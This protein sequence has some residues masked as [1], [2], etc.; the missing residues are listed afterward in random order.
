MALSWLLVA[1]H[2]AS[3]LIG[4]V[5]LL[6]PLLRLALAALLFALLATASLVFL[7]EERRLIAAGI[8]RT[9]SKVGGNRS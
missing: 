7:A 9:A 6:N 8:A 1:A 4:H 3:V 5:A 2:I